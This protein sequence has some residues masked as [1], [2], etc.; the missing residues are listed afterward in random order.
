MRSLDRVAL[1]R[2]LTQNPDGRLKDIANYLYLYDNYRIGGW[3]IVPSRPS[4]MMQ[5]RT[6]IVLAACLLLH[7]DIPKSRATTDLRCILNGEF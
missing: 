5:A 3:D 2:P 4:P 1:V 6:N 7:H